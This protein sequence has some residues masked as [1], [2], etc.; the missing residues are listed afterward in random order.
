MDYVSMEVA[1]QC[2]L[3]GMRVLIAEDEL[4]LAE[5]LAL[6]L[7]TRGASVVEI[8]DTVRWVTKAT[9]GSSPY[10]VVVLDLKL[11][12]GMAVDLAADLL[13][14]GM[15]VVIASAYSPDILDG[16]HDG[17]PFLAKPFNFYE[18]V[19]TIARTRQPA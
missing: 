19:L 17:A 15:P 9:Q 12:D 4:I 5:T 1:M 13:A 10:D 7:E 18:A 6:E 11:A 14:R 8:V 2:D 16:R 3:Q